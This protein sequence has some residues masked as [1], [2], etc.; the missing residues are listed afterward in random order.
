MRPRS[1]LYDCCVLL[2]CVSLFP[3]QR[4][5]WWGKGLHVRVSD[6]VWTELLHTLCINPG[7]KL[8]LGW[9]RSTQMPRRACGTE[10]KSGPPSLSLSLSSLFPLQT[11]THTFHLFPLSKFLLTPPPLLPLPGHSSLFLRLNHPL[12]AFLLFHWFCYV[13]LLLH[14]WNWRHRPTSLLLFN[15]RSWAFSQPWAI[16]V[17][18]RNITSHQFQTTDR[19]VYCCCVL[20][21]RRNFTHLRRGNCE[22]QQSTAR[23][24]FNKG[25]MELAQEWIYFLTDTGYCCPVPVPLAVSEPCIPT[26]LTLPKTLCLINRL[27]KCLAGT[28]AG[29]SEIS[30]S[31]CPSSLF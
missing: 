15:N 6:W 20:Y 14:L 1:Q 16:N 26:P 17:P 5:W 25:T 11:H 22:W 19:L 30:P 4:W 27:S 28:Q 29:P 7:L 3:K 9:K 13:Y 21:W 24:I 18:D 2:K 12:W 23:L 31:H 8:H 10:M